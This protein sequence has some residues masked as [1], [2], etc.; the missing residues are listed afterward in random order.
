MTAVWLL[1]FG[2]FI[3]LGVEIRIRILFQQI[4][5]WKY[6]MNRLN[7]EIKNLK[8][9]IAI[10]SKGEAKQSDRFEIK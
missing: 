4:S 1:L 9:E 7:E 3:L 10:P 8:A 5:E 6:G 2:L